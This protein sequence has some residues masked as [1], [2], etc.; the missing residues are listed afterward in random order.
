MAVLPLASGIGVSADGREAD[1]KFAAD[2]LVSTL[3]ARGIDARVDKKGKV[4]VVLLRQQTKKAADVLAHAQLNFDPA[5]H[6]EGYAIVTAGNTTYD[7]A[8][9]SAGIYYGAQT[10]KQ[11]VVG[12]GRNAVLHGVTIRDWPAMK[13]RGLDDD[14]SR[15]PVPTLAFQKHQIKVLSTS[16]FT[17]AA[18]IAPPGGAPRGLLA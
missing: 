9:T 11:L 3:K 6:D 15:G 10:I 14:L 18:D 2:D 7:I 8:A 5:M 16:S 4:K 17:S 12:R 1:D 13:Y